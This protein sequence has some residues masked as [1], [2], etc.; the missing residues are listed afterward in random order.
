MQINMATRMEMPNLKWYGY[1]DDVKSMMYVGTHDFLEK[2][3]CEN[4]LA[5]YILNT[6]LKLFQQDK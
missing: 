5:G 4:Y 3:D 1:A 2:E 6:W